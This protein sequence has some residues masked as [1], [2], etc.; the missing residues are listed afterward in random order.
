MYSGINS[1]SMEGKEMVIIGRN[2]LFRGEMHMA[3]GSTG[4]ANAAEWRDVTHLLG[5]VSD[6]SSDDKLTGSEKQGMMREW[7][8]ITTEYPLIVTQAEAY[9]VNTTTY[10]TAYHNVND[11]LNVV[12]RAAGEAYTATNNIEYFQ[13]NTLKYLKMGAIDLVNTSD[14][15]GAKLRALFSAYTAEMLKITNRITNTVSASVEEAKKEIADVNK[16]LG[17]FQSNVNGALADGIV[18]KADTA[19]IASDIKRLE[20]EKKDV[21]AGYSELMRNPYLVGDAKSMLEIKKGVYDTRH[22][23]LIS[24]I[25]TAIADGKATD[26]E[27][28]DV[29]AEFTAYGNTLGLYQQAMIQAHKAIQDE[30]KRLAEA[31]ATN[32]MNEAKLE[33]KKANEALTEQLRK[34]NTAITDLDVYIDGAFAN[35]IISAS[36]AQTI[37]KYINT[38]N[39]AKAT[40]EGTYNTLYLNVYLKGSAKTSLL[41]AKLNLFG[42]IENLLKEIN[43]AIA[44]GKTTITESANVDAK[45]VLF[46]AAS[47]AFN[48]AVEGANKAI[49]D[50]IKRLA[51]ADAAEKDKHA[52]DAVNDAAN[53]NKITGSEKQ[54]LKQYWDEINAEFPQI[55]EQATKYNVNDNA[56]KLSYYAVNDYM[57]I[58]L[59]TTGVKYFNT[60]ATW[61]YAKRDGGAYLKMGYINLSTTNDIDGAKLRAIKAKYSEERAKINKIITGIAKDLADNNTAEIKEVTVDIKKTKDSI[62]AVVT[63]VSELDKSISEA[64]FFTKDDGAAIFASAEL[65]NGTKLESFFEAMPEGATIKGKAVKIEGITSINGKTKVHEDGTFECVDALFFGSISTPFIKREG[66]GVLDISDNFNFQISS[67]ALYPTTVVL[68]NSANLNGVH[69]NIFVPGGTRAAG[70]LYIKQSNNKGFLGTGGMDNNDIK[71]LELKPN[72][73]ATLIAMPDTYS[74]SVVWFLQSGDI[75]RNS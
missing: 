18:D 17:D 7:D 9:N 66:D 23:A 58:A 71:T 60:Y 24:S 36:E 59:Y 14:I 56:F 48:Q 30:V 40:C 72:S 3:A 42:A 75:V 39:S 2:S 68:P 4:L 74:N 44:D 57:P 13:Y 67:L 1:F 50:E 15:N 20:I 31:D 55:I 16:A 38:I 41:N 53:V 47:K 22:N 61:F 64:G 69:C 11:Y 73:M 12:M 49:Q 25:N 35:G 43:T 27:K 8:I 10:T 6:A 5:Y 52:N 51:Q 63:S 37:A 32:K 19:L 34:T 33:A 46:N 62:K 29:N 70:Y 26:A 54:A 28:L 21:D 45:F 65:A